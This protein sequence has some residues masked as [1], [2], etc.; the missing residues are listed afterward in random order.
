DSVAHGRGVTVFPSSL[1]TGG[2]LNTF[3]LVTLVGR[4]FTSS[5]GDSWTEADAG[6]NIPGDRSFAGVAWVD[7][8]ARLAVGTISY[9]GTEPDVDTNA[10]GYYE[11]TTSSSGAP[12]SLSFTNEDI[13]DNYDGSE[14][15]T[16]GIARFVYYSDSD[17]LFALTHGRGLWRTNY[18]SDNA[19]GPEW[20]WE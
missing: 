16:S 6:S 13:S 20:F 7:H 14:L 4:V 8:R 2:A 12:Y 9:D 15:A 19:G 17:T 5:D 1:T 11:V 10:R 18:E 3:L